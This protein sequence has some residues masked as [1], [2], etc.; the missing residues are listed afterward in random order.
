MAGLILACMTIIAVRPA[1]EENTMT[2]H[3]FAPLS[4]SLL[5]SGPSAPPIS[6]LLGQFYDPQAMRQQMLSQGL[7]NAGLGMLSLEPTSYKRGLMGELASGLKGG[8]LG[9]QQAR[10][11]YTKSAFDA[12]TLDRHQ[13]DDQ[14]QTAE[15]Q[16]AE[17]ERMTQKKALWDYS[18]MLEA[19]KRDFL[20]AFPDIGARQ[21]AQTMFPDPNAGGGNDA[22][23]N[24]VY[25][26]DAENNLHAGQTLK[27]GGVKEVPLPGG[28]QWAPGMG[29]LDVGTGYVPYDKRTG[30]QD[31]ATSVPKDLRGAEAEKQIG[32]SAGK[33][34][35]DLPRAEATMTRA[36]GTID[37]L[38]NHPGREIATGKS[39]WIGG[40]YTPS[41]YD[42][43]AKLA[44][45]KGQTFLEAFAAL[46]GG[47]QVTEIEGQKATDAY[48]ALATAQSEEQFAEALS[49]LRQA[50]S[51]GFAKLQQQAAMAGSG[52]GEQGTKRYIYNPATGE[53][54]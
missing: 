33:A 25:W 37:A 15:R 22:S 29:Y 19:P 31:G 12:Y 39:A 49:E 34:A 28:G 21:A 36:I 51:D 4:G 53:L 20:R 13:Q 8:I 35:F 40:G 48:A 46:K 27:G 23:L 2:I 7:M 1:T 10:D 50:F 47:G 3:S 41:G 11:D 24:L 26:R 43:N 18:D 38:L 14:R 17:T 52:M 44:Q 32:Q 42:F 9:A 45:L 16:R 6:S 5:G 54:E 30:V